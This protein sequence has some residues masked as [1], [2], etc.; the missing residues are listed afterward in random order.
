MLCFL[1]YFCFFYISST[2]E[3]ITEDSKWDPCA[4][5]NSA[6]AHEHIDQSCNIVVLGGELCLQ[7]VHLASLGFVCHLHYVLWTVATTHSV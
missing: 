2:H 4:I 1:A 3:K 5:A 6:R 7:S